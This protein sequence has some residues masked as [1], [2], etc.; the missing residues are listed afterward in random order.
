MFYIL[1]ALVCYGLG[2]WT[3]MNVEKYRNP[4]RRR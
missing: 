1:T 3:G 4:N 2:V